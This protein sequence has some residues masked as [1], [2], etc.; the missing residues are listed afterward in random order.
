[1]RQV[2]SYLRDAEPQRYIRELGGLL[3]NQGIRV[4]IKD[5]ALALLAEVADPTAEEWAIWKHW[6]AAALQGIESGVQSPEK[7]SVLAWRRFFGSTSWFSDA[8]RRGLIEDWLASGHDRVVDMAMNYLWVHHPHA[9]DR[10]ASLLKP[11]V[12]RGGK[13]RH[14]LRSLM[15]KTQ[16]HTSRPYF[17]I[18]LR[19]VDNGTLDDDSKSNDDARSFSHKLYSVGENRPEWVP[20]AVAHRLRRQFAIIRKSGKDMSS[21]DLIG[22]DETAVRMIQAASERAPAEFIKHLLPVVL[23]ISSSSLIGDDLPKQDAVWHY[24][25]QSEPRTGEQACLFGLA[26]ALKSLAETEW[27]TLL[28]VVSDLRCRETYIANFLLQ[29]AYRAA[30]IYFADEA[31]LILCDQPWR[32]QCGVSESPHWDAMMLIRDVITHCSA[33]NKDKLESAIME[34]VGPFERP[35]AQLRREGIKCNGIGRTSFSLLSVIPKE[36][37]RPHA[38]RYF[39]ELKRRFG[40]P[41]GEPTAVSGG[42]VR[43]PIAEIAAVKM[44]DEQWRRAII[45]YPK[46]RPPYSWPDFLKGGAHELSQVL[47]EQAKQDPE[48]FGRLVLELPAD[49]NPAYLERVLNVL[50]DA[51]VD[52]ALKLRVCRKAYTD[53]R[54]ACGKSISDVLG[55]IEEPLPEDAVEML[56]WLATEHEHPKNEAWQEDAG[57]GQT[58]YNGEIYTN[59][60]NTTRGRAAEAIHRLILNDPIYIDRFLPTLDRMIIDRSA[61]VR[62][63]VAGALR[64][65]A[66]HDKA[67]GMSLFGRMDL[68]TNQLAKRIEAFIG[69]RFRDAP[70]IVRTITEGVIRAGWL[71]AAGLF[72]AVAFHCRV[73]RTSPL[74]KINQIEDRLLATRHVV[75]FISSHLR[76]EFPMLRS[77]IKRMVT[78]SDAN[79]CEVGAR[80]ASIAAVLIKEAA[81]LGKR[82]LRGGPH[83]RVGVAEVAAANLG[84][85]EFRDWCEARLVALFND[86]DS[87]VRQRASFCF[88]RLAADNLETYEDLIKEFCNSRAFAGGSFGLIQSLEKSL[89]HLPGITFLVC[90]RS[91][92]HPST[93][94]FA[95]AKLIFRTYHQHQ[96]DEWTSRTLDLI[97]GLCLDGYP[98]VG[99]ELEQF[100]R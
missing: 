28:R 52:Q 92:D 15:D 3:S 32:F 10:V 62:S 17:D 70:L 74:G 79:V 46:G 9:P 50:R 23:H 81:G 8:D 60:I 16:H 51:P 2:L 12:E 6:T 49:A 72:R 39:N 40:A 41:D 43:S 7:L 75:A 34:Y 54:I 4:H 65:V 45:K 95:V 30:P 20:E 69:N 68:T 21:S 26:S 66:Y 91:L 44:S 53:F 82:A 35:T 86:D 58:Y 13:W 14:R 29:S 93:D 33:P 37:R 42:F 63:C 85:S 22:F 1:M 100:D 19:L 5:L 38:D 48:R 99:T 83:G 96:D 57:K 27:H 73:L 78:S 76:H 47:G 71:C 80:L 90:E 89:S 77:I 61:A 84:V 18:L 98:G 67:L 87:N 88:V 55:S 64:A 97:D 59:G 25:S 94:A 24:L 36:M 31:V 11:Y 56:Q